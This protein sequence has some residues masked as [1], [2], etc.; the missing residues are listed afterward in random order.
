MSSAPFV[1]ALLLAAGEPP[2]A[3]PASVEVPALAVDVDFLCPTRATE[4]LVLTPKAQGQVKVPGSCPEAGAEWRFTVHC[5]D[6]TCTGL[7]RAAEGAIALINGSRE[8]LQV[9]PLAKEHPGTLDLL[10]LKVTGQYSL[11]M[12]STEEHQRPVQL[13][14]KHPLVEG[15][16]GLSPSEGIPVVFELKGKRLVLDSEVRWSDE[17][18]VH[19]RLR[20]PRGATV[21]DATLPLKEERPLSCQPLEGLCQGTLKLWVEV[22][23][24]KAAPP[25]KGATPAPSPP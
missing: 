2:D 4:S 11:T 10:S 7:I 18:H 12:P 22:P 8:R 21:F 25:S 16:Y 1:L 5:P 24:P 13:H 23:T 19:L 9:K 17:T 15:V 14:L 3:K 6:D 20:L